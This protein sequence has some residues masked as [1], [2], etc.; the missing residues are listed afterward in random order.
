MGEEPFPLAFAVAP[1]GARHH[2]PN[3]NARCL[4]DL[5]V[6]EPLHLAQNEYLAELDRQP[7]D[8]FV[9]KALLSGAQQQYLGCLEASTRRSGISMQLLVELGT[10]L[11]RAVLAQERISAVADHLAQPGTWVLAAEAVEEAERANHGLLHDVLGVMVVA[12]QP[13][14]EVVRGANVRQDNLLE[15]CKMIVLEH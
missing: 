3:G 13:A 14:R 12:H 5:L 4:R 1:S 6:R 10:Q 8:R 9:E 2:R 15:I 11:T 7:L